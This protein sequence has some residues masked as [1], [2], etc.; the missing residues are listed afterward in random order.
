[1]QIFPNV[2]HDKETDDTPD[3]S[4]SDDVWLLTN[5]VKS[6]TG[7]AQYYFST[8]ITCTRPSDTVCELPARFLP[9]IEKVAD[10]LVD[11]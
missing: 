3:A 8:N 1:M 4:V 9:L 11:E 7:D 2:T 5:V 10:V 6:I